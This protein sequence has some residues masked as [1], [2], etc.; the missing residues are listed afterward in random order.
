MSGLEPNRLP[1][2]L[3]KLYRDLMLRWFSPLFTD[4]VLNWPADYLHLR[5][6]PGR[7]NDHKTAKQSSS[8]S[9]DR[10]IHKE[11]QTRAET[12]VETRESGEW[13]YHGRSAS[14]MAIPDPIP[15][16]MGLAAQKDEGFRRFYK[17]VVSPTHVR[18]TAGGR[19][20]P[21]TRGPASPTTKWNNKDKTAPDGPNPPRPRGSLPVDGPPLVFTQPPFNPMQAFYP[22]VSP[23]MPHMPHQMPFMPIPMGYGLAPGLAIPG[24]VGLNRHPSMVAPNDTLGPDVKN[25]GKPAEGHESGA[26]G[27]VR[28]SPPEQFDH[29]R[30]FLYNNQWMMPQPS[31]LFHLGMMGQPMLPTTGFPGPVLAAPSLNFNANLGHVAYQP[32]AGFPPQ[33]APSSA[34][35]LLNAPPAMG[36]TPG[37]LPPSSIR[38][39]EITK[40]HLE[41]LRLS[42]KKCEDQLQY[43]RHQIDERL[44]EQHA[45]LIRANLQQFEAK[46][47]NELNHEKGF[48]AKTENPKNSSSAE[49]SSSSVSVNAE[50]KPLSTPRETSLRTPDHS[51]SKSLAQKSKPE[52]SMIF[53]GR[54]SGKSMPSAFALPGPVYDP[55]KFER[56]RKPTGLPSTAALAPPFQPRGETPS[57]QPTVKG[58][59]TPPTRS[60][61][62]EMEAQRQDLSQSGSG[63]RVTDVDFREMFASGNLPI[64]AGST[65]LVSEPSTASVSPYLVGTLPQGIDPLKAKSTDFVYSRPLTDEELR[66]R[67]LHWGQ[68]PASVLQGLPK[69]DGKDF[70]A[71][72]CDT[73]PSVS[74]VHGMKGLSVGRSAADF[75]V[76]VPRQERDPVATAESS[77]SGS[78]QTG[79]AQQR[80][81]GRETYAFASAENVKPQAVRSFDLPPNLTETHS[82]LRQWAV[83]ERQSMVLTSPT[84]PLPRPKTV[85]E[86]TCRNGP[87][88]AT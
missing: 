27:A 18:V 55:L 51:A 78:Q 60:V 64:R 41:N 6:R 56:V 23:G 7:S 12:H 63:L 58:L 36:H 38:M 4:R 75:G 47:Q 14:E 29:N 80:D 86:R 49:S 44:M 24:P 26:P 1:S 54:D 21:N 9:E 37:T 81:G 3:E 35:P 19:I 67:Y 69:F 76:P 22:A 68:A 59:S 88:D 39:S 50:P 82:F 40:K 2:H 15:A 62:R 32:S 48:A 11:T 20:V 28:I 74:P 25:N 46:L 43:N 57:A 16:P 52:S 31:P 17:A 70:Y 83:S 73:P 77:T 13:Q 8:E 79:T 5:R 10:S 53:N 71:A 61:Q 33:Q 87:E 30:P 65:S 72:T 66:A 42:L 85:M 34:G 84:Q 45:D